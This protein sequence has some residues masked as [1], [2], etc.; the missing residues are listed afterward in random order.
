VQI[1]GLSGQRGQSLVEFAASS[2]VLVLLFGGLV[3]LTRAIHFGDVLQGGARE[4]ARTGSVFSAGTNSNPYLDDADIKTAVDSHLKAG[5]LPASS[6]QT[7]GCPS[8][9]DGNSVHNPPYVNGA[10]PTAAN[11]PYLYVC[12]NNS[13]ATDYPTTPATG[14]RGLDLN[15]ILVL[16]YGPFTSVIPGPLSG[17]FGVSANWHARIQGG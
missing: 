6:L 7:P 10:F 3:D 17:N 2:V 9:T 16:S 15:V 11:S 13:G 8:V 4:G 1:L 12:Y 14:L 5:G